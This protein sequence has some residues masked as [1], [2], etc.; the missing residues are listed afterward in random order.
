MSTQIRLGMQILYGIKQLHEAGYIHRDIKPA[1][2]A[3]GRKGTEARM[4]HL[5]DFGLAREYI[6][7]N[8]DTVEMRRPRDNTL[9]R[10]TTK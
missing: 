4:V 5:L 7:R 1:N 3:V 6:L 10:G 2:L 8:E 9:F